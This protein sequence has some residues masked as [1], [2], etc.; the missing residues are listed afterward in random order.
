M[1][2]GSTVVATRATPVHFA[3]LFE[4][5]RR[6]RPDVEVRLLSAAVSKV[7]RE[8]LETVRLLREMQAFAQGVVHTYKVRA[9]G[10]GG[11]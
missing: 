8:L 1:Q 4:A 7:A 2:A 5:L 6:V 3:R 9:C 10:V 11:W